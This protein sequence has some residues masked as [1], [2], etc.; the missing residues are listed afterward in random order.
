MHLVHQSF[1]DYMSGLVHGLHAVGIDIVVTTVS[2]GSARLT[3]PDLPA[4]VEHR[5][6]SIPRFRDPRSPLGALKEVRRLL[7]EPADVVHWQAAGSP[8][9]DMAFSLIARNRPTVVTVHDMEPHPGDRNVLPGAF[10]AIH[11]LA[12][13]ADQVTVHAPHIK[14]QAEQVGVDPGRVSII[15]HGEL[16]TGYKTAA[17]LPLPP[18]EGGPSVLFFGRAQGYKGLDVLWEAMKR[19]NEGDRPIELVVAGSGPSLDEVLPTDAPLPTWCRVLRG[20]IPR[21]D[22]VGLFGRASVVALPYR[23]ASQSGVAALA[24]GFG[25]PVVASSVP[26]LSDIVI[27]GETGLLVAPGK[28]DELADAIARLADQPKL[29]EALSAGAHRHAF[30]GLSWTRIA[31]Q[32]WDVYDRAAM[33]TTRTTEKA[34]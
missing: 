27:D 15:A 25:R 28:P 19:L 1:G 23:E 11:R 9:V 4:A 32:L 31:E 24:A 34:G 30:A 33:A 16:A 17:E 12:R 10:F 8:W 18:G 20:H 7:S 13:R 6:V 26:G 3:A 14:T 22:V 21:E 5:K 2:T 29:S